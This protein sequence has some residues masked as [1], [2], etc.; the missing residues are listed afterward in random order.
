[1]APAGVSATT[2][3]DRVLTDL[4][5]LALLAKQ[6]E[7]NLVGPTFRSMRQLLDELAAMS[8]RQADDVAERALTLGHHPDGRAATIARND[9]LSTI[10][11]GTM[12]VVALIA[13]VGSILD[14]VVA[15]VHEAIEVVA[16]DP[17]TRDLFTTIVGC[18]ERQSWMIR[19]HRE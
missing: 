5:N 13:E 18:V 8:R 4:I 6:A 12:S 1:M 15:Q 2:A 14:T 17:V 9:S 11:A 19:S 10:P 7:W 16:D 3:I